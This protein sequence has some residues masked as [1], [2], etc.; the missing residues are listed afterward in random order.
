MTRKKRTIART[1]EEKAQKRDQI[2]DAAY[3]M[4]SSRGY[5]EATMGK[6]A[7]KAGVSHGTLYWH[8]KSKE[9]LFFAVLERE[10]LRVDEAIRP[11]L[12]IEQP[13]LKKI[14]MLLRFSVGTLEQSSTFLTLFF[15]AM[16]GSGER[17]ER[18]LQEMA[19]KMYSTY[20][21][22]L[23]EI[24]IQGQKEGDIREDVNARA[25]A[26]A[27]VS[28]LDALYLQYGLGTATMD[29]QKLADGLWDF[30]ERGLVK[31]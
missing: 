21:D 11:A 31:Q 5:H 24:I 10:F 2:L 30:M 14:E 25:V 9:D 1:Q 6:I 7:R 17:F 23:E 8:F 22:M 3:E 16:A 26:V 4:L 28:L 18:S 12:A 19:K 20:N 27:M 15:S 13:A 29:H